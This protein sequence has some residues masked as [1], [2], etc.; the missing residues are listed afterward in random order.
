VTPP[1]QPQQ[2]WI[3]NIM[4]IHSVGITPEAATLAD[5]FGGDTPEDTIEIRAGD[6]AHALEQLSTVPEGSPITAVCLGTPHFS[7]HE[8]ERLC[9]LLHQVAPNRG[10]PIYVNTG[11]AT[12]QALED[13]GVLEG[14]EIRRLRHDSLEL[15]AD[16][17]HLAHG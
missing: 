5:A 8:W 4:T 6:I 2:R 7:R 15:L 11:R 16:R 17:V 10:V 1:R 3:H 12:L 9:P 13:E 14:Q